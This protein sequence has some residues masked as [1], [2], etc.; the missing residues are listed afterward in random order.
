MLHGSDGQ[1]LDANY[2]YVIVAVPL[3]QNQ[4]IQIEGYRASILSRSI[5]FIRGRLF[6]ETDRHFM[7]KSKEG[8]FTSYC[9][10]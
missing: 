1:K 3:H 4:Q 2:N 6:F 7:L 10:Y 5:S 9:L 8:L